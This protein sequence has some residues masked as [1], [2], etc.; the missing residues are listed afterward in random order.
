MKNMIQAALVVM[1]LVSCETEQELKPL[2]RH[3]VVIG[4]DGMSPGGIA[5]AETP[6]LDYFIENGASTMTARAVLPTSSSPN[7]AS[8]I[9]GAGPEQHGITSNGWERENDPMPPAVTGVENIF[10]SI[11]SVLKIQQ[12]EAKSAV[13][14]HWGGFGRLF[15]K[16]A[17]SFSQHGEDQFVTTQIATEQIK[18]NQPR[19]TFVHLDHVD[20]AGHEYGH[21]TDHY[22]TSVEEADSL[23]GVIREA[24]EEAGMLDETVFLITSDHGGLNY[25][26]GGESLAEIQIPFILCGTGI[27]K[28]YEIPESVYT[29][30]NA[31]TVAYLLGLERPQAW[32]GRPVLSAV[33][34]NEYDDPFTFEPPAMAKVPA[35][36]IHP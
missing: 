32:I 10:P 9:M 14:Y 1:M 17:V 13:I 23:I 34:G 35:P 24:V 33:E 36:E 8:M 11:F 2:A 22:Y 28:N 18:K 21:G 29:Y 25:G 26:H 31:A 3:V 30:D 7:W 15:E 16:S 20:H 4:V 5:R 27:K 6:N 12:P 19:L